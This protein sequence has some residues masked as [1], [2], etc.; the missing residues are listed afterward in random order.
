MD[1]EFCFP[2]GHQWEKYNSLAP[3]D[4]LDGIVESKA[5]DGKHYST[6]DFEPAS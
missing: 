3:G 1:D 4:N 2:I 6:P 5:D